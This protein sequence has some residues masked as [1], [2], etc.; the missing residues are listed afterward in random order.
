LEKG[1]VVINSENH[2]GYHISTDGGNSWTFIKGCTVNGKNVKA[3][4][5]AM[6]ELKG[7]IFVSRSNGPLIVSTDDLK[8]FKTVE[9][10]TGS[11]ALF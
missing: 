4:F 9:D 11:D 5:F 8:T 1:R 10:P 3:N 6:A 7:S 2:D